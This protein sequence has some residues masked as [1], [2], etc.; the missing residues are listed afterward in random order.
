[1]DQ[2]FA[3]DMHESFMSRA[4]ELAQK[5]R[6]N[7][8]PNPLVGCVLVKEGEIIGEGYHA[9]FGGPHAEVIALQ[10]ARKDPI[11]A[12]AYINLEP[13]SI[14][15]KTPPCTDI[16]IQN[17]IS[18]VYVSMLDPNPDIHGEGI[19][20][21]KRAGIKVH[22]GIL[23]SEA[24]SLNRPF[25]K[26]ITTGMPWV[27]AKVAQ[28][29]NGYMGVT[30]DT[31]TQITGKAS[32]KHVHALRASVDAIMVGRKTAEI[33]DPLLTVREV[34]GGNPKRVILD[35]KRTLPLELNM[36]QD[37]GAQTIVLCS[38]DLFHRSKTHF[39]E[40]LPVQE[41]N[42]KLVPSDIL[43]VLANEGITSVLIEG[44]R[45][46]IHSFITE[47]LI[48]QIYVYTAEINLK[49]A[50]LKNPIQLSEDWTIVDEL[51]F[52]KDQLII[53]EKGVECLQEL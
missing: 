14:S 44:G 53:A 29:K 27:I 45:E 12:T 43:K 6:G 37:K 33:D 51:S 2:L 11:D 23:E 3:I 16:L 19:E 34:N 42:E 46:I 13:C 50:S 25:K 10:N 36:F 24:E 49:N 9:T 35:T 30:S 1:M 4:L 20:T 40:Y 31:S 17:S 22:L 26:W 15:S 5:G 52:D 8:S 32:Q 48:D 39:C 47:D 28:S 21:L 18:E 38:K 7:V 41:E